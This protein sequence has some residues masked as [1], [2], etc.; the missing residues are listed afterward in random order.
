ML[1]EKIRLRWIAWEDDLAEAVAAVSRSP[2]DD[3]L[4]R[5]EAGAILAAI[6]SMLEVAARPGVATE[7][8]AALGRAFEPLR[9]GFGS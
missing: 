3:P 1:L 5:T 9:R 7:P 2:A 6:R 8:A 4:P